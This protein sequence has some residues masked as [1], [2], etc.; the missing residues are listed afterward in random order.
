[1]R[2]RYLAPAL[3]A[4]LVVVAVACDG[5]DSTSPT[6]TP[7]ATPSAPQATVTPVPGVFDCDASAETT[8]PDPAAF[9]VDITD[10]VDNTIALQAPPQRIASLS[11]GHT[12]I[13]YAIGAGDQVAAVDSTSDCPREA[14]DLPKVDAFTP[15]V[16][17]IAELEPDLVIIFFDPGDLQSSL[18]GLDIP[19]LNLA[20]PESVDGVYDQV[21]LLGEATGQVDEATD[22]VADMQAAVQEIR[23]EIGDVADAPT[24]FHEIDNTYFTAGPGSFIADLYDI[25][26]AENIADATGQAFPQMSAE[27]IIEADPEVIVLADEDA[28]E[29]PDTVKAR[30]GWDNISA[31]QNGRVHIVDPDIV[32]RPGPRLVEAL[33]T[34]AAYLYPERFP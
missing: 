29:T 12:E 22:L 27:A 32:S 6:A 31:V 17:A 34:L 24:V 9:P 4:L 19:V 33:R 23:S 10:S 2:L 11:A 8:P 26:G 14:D 5:G 15:S 30:P 20:S 16:E 13:L 28:G 18:Q 7:S 3:A 1:M 25:L 21:E